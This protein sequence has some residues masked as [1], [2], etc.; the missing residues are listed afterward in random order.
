MG[1]YDLIKLRCEVGDTWALFQMEL[2]KQLGSNKD[3]ALS[4][5]DFLNKM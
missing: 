5:G 1:L 2:V 4:A 3:K